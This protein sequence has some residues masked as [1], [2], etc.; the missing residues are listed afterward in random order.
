VVVKF[1]DILV[2]E[3][4]ATVGNVADYPPHHFISRCNAVIDVDAQAWPPHILFLATG[5][6]PREPKHGLGRHI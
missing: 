1:P 6:K 3:V 2:L 4:Y 5:V